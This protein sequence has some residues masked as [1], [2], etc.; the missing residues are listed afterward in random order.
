[1]KPEFFHTSL[2]SFSNGDM[3]DPFSDVELDVEELCDYLMGQIIQGLIEEGKEETAS[4]MLACRLEL[5]V[6]EQKRTSRSSWSSNPLTLTIVGPVSI[7]KKL[8]QRDSG[9]NMYNNSETIFNQNLEEFYSVLSLAIGPK[10]RID[11][12]EYIRFRAETVNLPSDWRK[13]SLE[14]VRKQGTTNQGLFKGV[15]SYKPIMYQNLLFRSQSEV[16]I[17]KSLDRHKVMYFANCTAR[18]NDGQDRVNREPDFVICH[19]GNWGALEVDGEPF[20][21]PS[22][23]VHDHERDRIFQKHGLRLVQHYDSSRC[24]QE[25]EQ[26]VTEFLELLVNST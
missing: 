13:E 22:R 4:M 19:N 17:A 2:Q 5:E 26:V 23:T 1:M 10:I 6:E 18:V 15:T 14:A 16:K 11:A 3:D 7:L 9:V 20:H 12:L 24:Y 21:P 25:P 8:Q